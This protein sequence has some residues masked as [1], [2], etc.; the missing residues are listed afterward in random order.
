MENL[1]LEKLIEAEAKRLSYRYGKDFFDYQDLMK[2]MGLGK[3]NIR[4]LMNSSGF[5]VTRVGKRQVVS[6]I[7]FARWLVINDKGVIR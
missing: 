2:V 3:D 1:Q 5:P 4:T 7:N 6:I